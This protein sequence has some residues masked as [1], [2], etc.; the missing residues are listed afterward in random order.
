MRYVRMIL[1]FKEGYTLEGVHDYGLDCDAK[2]IA[3]YLN[4]DNKMFGDQLSTFAFEEISEEK[5]EKY[6]KRLL[7]L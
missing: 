2:T 3:F 4:R 6:K 5:F 1:K 7:V